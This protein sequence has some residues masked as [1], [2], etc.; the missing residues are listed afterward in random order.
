MLMKWAGLLSIVVMDGNLDPSWQTKG[1]D[2]LSHMPLATTLEGSPRGHPWNVN[3]RYI[4]GSMAMID[5]ALIEANSG[6]LDETFN[7]L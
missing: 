7:N 3:M 1:S 4:R 5:S 2:Y 6:K